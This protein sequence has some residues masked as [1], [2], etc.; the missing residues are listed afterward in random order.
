MPYESDNKN[1]PP[2]FGEL[3]PELSDEELKEAEENFRRY[4][5]FLGRLYKRLLREGYFDNHKVLTPL[6]E[7]DTTDV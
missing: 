4:V 5:A 7:D 2:T 6:N 1:G 3:Y